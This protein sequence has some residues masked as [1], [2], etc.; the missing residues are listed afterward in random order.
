MGNI[1]SADFTK[2]NISQHKLFLACNMAKEKNEDLWFIDSGCSNHMT[3]NISMFSML[4]ENVKPQVTL[5]ID[6]KVFVMGKRRVSVLTRK[7]ENKSISD[8]Y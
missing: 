8:V 6:S 3:G 2:E 7:G 4:D 5:G 1:H